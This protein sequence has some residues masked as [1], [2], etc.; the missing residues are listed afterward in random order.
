MKH[1]RTPEQTQ[2]LKAVVIPACK[3]DGDDYVVKVSGY[4][5]ATRYV[6][7]HDKSD[8]EDIVR[9][10]WIAPSGHFTWNQPKGLGGRPIYPWVH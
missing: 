8:P 10:W 7:Q 9:I 6:V 1:P 5:S 2:T 3:E 4:D